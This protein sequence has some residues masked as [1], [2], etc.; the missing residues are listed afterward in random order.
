MEKVNSFDEAKAFFDNSENAGKSVE[1]SKEG[2]E[3]KEVSSVEEAEAYFAPEA[4]AGSD[5]G[6][7]AG[8]QGADAGADAGDGEPVKH[9]YNILSDFNDAAGEKHVAGTTIQLTEE[10]AADLL[11]SGTIAKIEA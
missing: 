7:A 3:S 11:T 8:D 1:C 5:A 9:N 2:F 4:A 6:A 10:E